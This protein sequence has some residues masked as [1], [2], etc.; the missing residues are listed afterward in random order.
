MIQRWPDR[1]DDFLVDLAAQTVFRRFSG[2]FRGLLSLIFA[3]G[4][5]A[6][7]DS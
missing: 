5:K 3:H 7:I 1:R 4:K 2:A 6:R